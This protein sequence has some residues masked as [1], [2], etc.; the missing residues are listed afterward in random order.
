MNE[1]L[2]AATNDGAHECVKFLS[3]QIATLVSTLE[4]GQ[5]AGITFITR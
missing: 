2:D 4:P 1:R 5:V 3:S